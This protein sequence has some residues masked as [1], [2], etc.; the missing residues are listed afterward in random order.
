MLSN[1]T[2]SLPYNTLVSADA[3]PSS[4]LNLS[5][6]IFMSTACAWIPLHKS[7]IYWLLSPRHMH[8]FLPCINNT[9]LKEFACFGGNP[10][11]H[12]IVAHNSKIQNKYIYEKRIC[13]LIYLHV[14]MKE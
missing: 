13:L 7:F 3:S 2:V 8:K 4:R 1:R 11:V 6:I 9:F 12:E 10:S 14:Y 5:T